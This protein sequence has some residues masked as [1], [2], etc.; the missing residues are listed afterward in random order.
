MSHG[1]TS[2]NRNCEMNE[3]IETI[4]TPNFRIEID[5]HLSDRRS[6]RFEDFR[7][8]HLANGRTLISG[9]LQDQAQLFGILIQ[10]RDM[11]LPILSINFTQ[12][13]IIQTE[14]DSK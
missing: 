11:G 4:Q 5:G 10:F 2:K 1:F 6:K 12:P 8:A 7:V 9:S 14:G 13:K 3:K